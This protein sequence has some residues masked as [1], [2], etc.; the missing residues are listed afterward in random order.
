MNFILYLMLFT[1][2]PFNGPKHE[3]K[4][5]WSLQS[6]STL[7]FKTKE[8]CEATGY[9]IMQSLESVATVTVRGWCFCESTNPLQ[10]CPSTTDKST[11]DML[12]TV[13]P[14][15]KPD[16]SFGVFTLDPRGH[17]AKPR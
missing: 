11:A 2:A 5:L 10:I 17:S 12:S 3:T 8:A 4:H 15:K 16:T 6:T 7:N 1:T 14:N 9:A 13:A